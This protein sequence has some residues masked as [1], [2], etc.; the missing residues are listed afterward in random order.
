MD[1]ATCRQQIAEIALDPL[2]AF[3]FAARILFATFANM[4]HA[5]ERPGAR[6]D[7]NIWLRYVAIQ[8]RRDHRRSTARFG[9]DALVARRVTRDVVLRVL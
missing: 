8:R 3:S 6:A 1:P 5:Q 9:K 2:V 7:G 4:A